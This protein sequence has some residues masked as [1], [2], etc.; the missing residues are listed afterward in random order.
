VAAA[1]RRIE[2]SD[3]VTSA[4]A[5]LA[6]RFPPPG[7][8]DPSAELGQ[9]LSGRAGRGLFGNSEVWVTETPA[10]VAASI[11]NQHPEQPVLTGSGDRR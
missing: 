2:A 9:A 7:R 1:L 4:S 11:L 3:D 5:D 10:R 6:G 8:P